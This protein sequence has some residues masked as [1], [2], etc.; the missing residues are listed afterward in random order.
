M[1]NINEIDKNKINGENKEN[2]VIGIEGMVSSGK[3]SM[4]KE[5]IKLIPNTIYIDAGYIYRGIILAIIKNKIDMNSAKGNIL[6]L[7]KQLD[8]EFNVEDGVT[9]IY[10][11]GE[12]ISEE[13]V[14]SMQN[15]MG[16]SK[17]ASMSDNAPLFAFARN[18]IDNYK[19]HFNVICSGRDMV[20]IYPN[21]NCHL[22][23]TASLDARVKRRF[24]QY[25]GKYTEEEI[26]KC[27][28]ERDELHEQT[29]FNKFC[30]VTIKIDLTDCNSAKESAEKVLSILKEKQVL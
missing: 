4:C 11:E 23:I 22:F 28:Q 2:L 26:R 8:V 13:E 16:V 5:L 20:D 18:V 14:E 6:N 21:M 12:K 29:G 19:Q 27:I 3:S 7:M 30:D 25:K 10:I 1:E 9:Q 17:M 24:N 15:S